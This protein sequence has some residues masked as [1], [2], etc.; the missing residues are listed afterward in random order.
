MPARLD[1]VVDKRFDFVIVGGG[2]AGL[3]LAARLTEDP[4]ISVC[5]L[6]AGAAHLNDPDLIRPASF[7]T[8]FGQPHYDW[9][10][11][12][13]AQKHCNGNQFVWQRGKGLGG[14][15]GINFLCWSK[16]PK[17]DVDDIERLG[18]PGWNWNNYQKYS[19]R[20]EKFVYPTAEFRKNHNLELDHWESGHEGSLLTAFP[21]KIPKIELEVQQSLLNLGLSVAH[22]PLG[23]DPCGI[24]F[25]PNTVDPKT[26]TRSYSTT[27]FYLP[28]IHRTNLTVLVHAHCH[29]IITDSMTQGVL[30]KA[31]GVEFECEGRACVVHAVREVVLCAGALKSPQILELSGI[32]QREVLEKIGMRT[33]V[34]LPSVGENVQEH[35]F[36]GI[37]YELKDD[38]AFETLDIL[39]DPKVAAE[40]IELHTVGEGVYTLGIVGF[41][42][43]P[44]STLSPST[45]EHVYSAMKSKVERET[46]RYDKPGMKEMIDIQLGRLDKGA[47]CCEIVTYPGC[48][49]FP[50]P[51]KPGKKY[52]SILVATNHNFSRGTI[53]CTSP[54]PKEDPAFDPH[55]FEEEIDL[56]TLVDTVKFVRTKLSKTA[57]FCDMIVE[58][59]N[60]GPEVQTDEDIG[61]WL[62][63]FM[64]TTFHTV[65]SCSMLPKD[66]GGVVGPDLKVYGTENI[67]VVD[68][69]VVPLHIAAHTQATAYAIAEQAADILKQSYA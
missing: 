35:V 32:G 10:F 23:G 21:A 27:A 17:E 1:E 57:P 37:V 8:H 40:H 63:K 20:T 53:H 58:E 28:N 18:N 25:G 42:F 50:A 26:H 62:K 6:E 54:D 15:S 43:A 19:H 51:P 5:V 39:R 29:R 49:G 34:E 7:G 47:P 14:S 69:S 13:T 67:R 48:L 11:R 31:T 30:A 52:I 55:Y 65:G 38:A 46:A 66:K 61:D 60:P 4:N 3:C 9:C 44:L 12:T 2:T 22:N 64:M 56:Q 68:L 59:L 24:F 36:T 33:V 41:A 45:A 16:P